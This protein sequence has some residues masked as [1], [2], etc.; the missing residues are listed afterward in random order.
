MIAD[1]RKEVHSLRSEV[2]QLEGRVI[3][4]ESQ[5]LAGPGRAESEFEVVSVSEHQPLLPVQSLPVAAAAAVHSPG[6]PPD[7]V[8]AAHKIGQFLRRCLSGEPRGSSGR[9]RIAAP[10][11][12]Y[13]ICQGYDKQVYDPPRIYFSWAEAKPLV[14]KNG[15][16]GPSIFVG[17]PTISEAR[18]AVEA[19][20][21]ELP[22]ALL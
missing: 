18:I 15:S 6:L 19:A 21:C 22:G 13:I 12:V 17:V 2:V 16:P 14:I 10:S 9:D 11:S 7:R 5:Q 20:G 8:A 4:L 1:L 3:E